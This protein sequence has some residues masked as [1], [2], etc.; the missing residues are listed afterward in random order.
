[1]SLRP[2]GRT[3]LADALQCCSQREGVSKIDQ[4]IFFK[5]GKEAAVGPCASAAA[6]LCLARLPFADGL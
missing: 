2:Y 3:V 5:C 6:P 1:M 4:L